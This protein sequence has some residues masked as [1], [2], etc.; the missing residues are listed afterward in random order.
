MISFL[1][2]KKYCVE[3]AKMS[4]YMTTNSRFSSR[5]TN[6]TANNFIAIVAKD[7]RIVAASVGKPMGAVE[8]VKLARTTDSIISS[9]VSS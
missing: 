1:Y 4:H 6:A 5:S 8:A 9:V 7:K 2:Q 3:S